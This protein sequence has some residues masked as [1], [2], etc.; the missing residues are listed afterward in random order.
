MQA[1]LEEINNLVA[2]ILK[3]TNILKEK[4][5]LTERGKGQ[6]DTALEVKQILEHDYTEIGI[7]NSV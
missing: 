7:H 5:E 1:I 6:E 2:R 4:G 3:D